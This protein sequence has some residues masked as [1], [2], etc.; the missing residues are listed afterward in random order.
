M[1]E[2]KKLE[3]SELSGP[4]KRAERERFYEAMN[5]VY[6]DKRE[7]FPLNKEE[8][9]LVFE[10]IGKLLDPDKQAKKTD[11]ESMCSD[12][13]RGHELDPNDQEVLNILEYH[14]GTLSTSLKNAHEKEQKHSM[15]NKDYADYVN[16]VEEETLSKAALG[17]YREQKREKNEEM[18]K[19]R[20]DEFKAK[21]RFGFAM[22]KF[23]NELSRVS[24]K[25][26]AQ[27]EVKTRK[28]QDVQEP[29]ADKIRETAQIADPEAETRVNI[30]PPT[31]SEEATKR[32]EDPRYHETEAETKIIQ[33]PDTL[34]PDEVTKKI[35]ADA[36]EV[37]KRVSDPNYQR[38]LQKLDFNLNPETEKIEIKGDSRDV[39]WL[40]M[41]F[42]IEAV[43]KKIAD[44]TFEL[45]KE[46]A[47][48]LYAML[49]RTA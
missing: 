12:I 4:E 39:Q 17:R 34:E 9:Q 1:S 15:L 29:I 6:K 14:L 7:S 16:S 40:R 20:E 38:M 24:K 37:T 32:I 36:K 8:Q 19:A 22:R 31:D 45:T 25:P 23:E 18:N 26:K 28:I 3:Y 13:I 27:E 48:K 33:M 44:R 10:D 30:T 11:L 5:N 41:R 49:K 47:P 21:L 2:S 35:L 46:E 42:N 43:P